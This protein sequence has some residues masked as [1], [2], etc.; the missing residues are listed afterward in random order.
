[1][2]MWIRVTLPVAAGV[3]LPFITQAQDVTSTG[4]AGDIA[5]LQTTLEQ[6][7]NTMIGNCS[8]LIGIGRAIAGFGA[9]L[10]IAYRLWGSLARAETVDVF[11]LLRPF[12][13]GIVI[14]FFPAFI[15]LL[16]GALAPTVIGTSALVTNS[17]QAIST[18]LQQ[19]A[20]AEQ[21]STEWQA[22][23]GTDGNGSM[24]KWEEYTGNTD[25][26]I[27][28]GLTNWAKFEMAK[29]AYNF[30]N[31]IKVWLSE[32]LE[33]LFEAAALCINTV[34]TFYLLILAILGPIVFGLS[35]FDGLHHVLTAWIARYIN[36]FLWLP[37][38]NIYGSLIGQIQAQMLQIDI[39]QVQSTGQ[40]SFGSTDA[41][42]IVFLIMGIV[43][44]F[45]VP[46]IAGWVINVGGH[47]GHL[48]KTT[49]M[50]GSAATGAVGMVGNVATGAVGMG[51]SAAGAGAAQLGGALGGMVGAPGGFRAGYAEGGQSDGSSGF[52]KAGRAYGRA[53]SGVSNYMR[54]KLS[55][56]GE[57]PKDWKF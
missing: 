44:Y 28:G 46:S 11:S 12:A 52:S 16:N 35:V 6:V 33:V 37:I 36:I 30:K 14:T 18:L 9:L 4:L 2:K 43:G 19:K 42:Y 34:R 22:Y 40:T 57:Q 48:G 31:S 8:E 41:A 27:T 51:L 20:Q 29:A 24:E 50:A 38:A 25:S 26:G 15:G 53:S 32:I 10:Y 17:N 55:G 5:G 3:L 54:D 13:T 47:G 21:N 56:T 1:M 49:S 45:T 23:V 39:A 7:Y